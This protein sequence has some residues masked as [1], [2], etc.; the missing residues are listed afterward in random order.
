MDMRNIILFTIL[1]LSPS[2]SF[3]QDVIY[4]NDKSEIKAKVVEITDE[5]IK[6]KKY[7]QADG[8]LRNINK[9]DVFIIIYEDGTRELFNQNNADPNKAETPDEIAHEKAIIY[10]VQYATPNFEY[11]HNDQY[12][13]RLNK[14]SYF[15]YECPPGKQVIWAS[16]ENKELLYADLKPGGYYIIYIDATIGFWKNHVRLQPIDE[17][18]TEL[19]EKALSMISSKAPVVQ[20]QKEINDMNIRL[21]AFIKEH[22]KFYNPEWKSDKYKI[23]NITPEM[24]VPQPRKN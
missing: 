13:G 11:F 24:D 7:D 16:S 2:L 9:S 17:R 10:F 12:I 23:I 22:W 5:V 6:Y 3:C 21:S 8:P 18:N 1:L 14:K 4:K 20:N 15:V 19:Y